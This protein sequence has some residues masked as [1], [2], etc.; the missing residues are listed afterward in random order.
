MKTNNPSAPASAQG[1]VPSSAAPAPLILVVEDYIGLRRILEAILQHQGYRTLGLDSGDDVLTTPRA[2]LMEAACA[3]VDDSLP[4]HLTGAQTVALLHL[5][6]PE[7]QIFPI[8]GRKF[9][10]EEQAVMASHYQEILYK[11]FNFDRLLEVVRNAIGDCAL[12][13]HE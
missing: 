4:G 9:D 12:P 8:P 2:V 11:P 10:P 1:P 5:I 3:L 13:A 7:M 6:N